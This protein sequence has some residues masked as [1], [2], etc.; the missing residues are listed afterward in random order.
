MGRA[1]I[2]KERAIKLIKIVAD[3]CLLKP[4]VGIRA[5][6]FEYRSYQRWAI[7]ELIKH[8]RE[9]DLPLKASVEEFIFKMGHFSNLNPRTAFLFSI[10]M[11]VGSDVY[12]SLKT[13]EEK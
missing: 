5:T 12:N 7:L 10:A 11:D 1:R 8:V 9:S 13:M 2:A 6:C 4:E 3:E